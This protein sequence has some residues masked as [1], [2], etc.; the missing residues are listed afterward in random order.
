[1]QPISRRE[2]DTL[3]VPAL[4]SAHSHAFQRGLRGMAQ[5]KGNPSENFWTWRGAM[6][7]LAESLTPETID[8]FSRQAFR[9]LR[10]AGVRT[11]G[12][13]HYVHHQSGGHPYDDR[14]LL[15]DIVIR[16]ALDEGLRITLLRTAYNRG[17]FEHKIDRA[18]LRFS[19]K[20]VDD[21]LRDTETL[22]KRYAGDARVRIGLAPHSVRAVPPE[23]LRPLGEFAR[24]HDLPFHMHISEQ[25][26]EVDEC[27]AETGKRPL[28][29]VN[30]A[31]LLSERFC[32]V[33]ATQLS[34][35]EV[36]LLGQA[37]AFACLCPTTERDLGDGIADITAL[38]VA[39]VR[40]CNGIDS[41]I[42]T[43]PIEEIRSLET[44]ERLRTH[45]RV[46]FTNEGRTPA[47]S[48]WLEGS[49]NGSMACGFSD[50]GG[51]I[52]INA[53]HESLRFVSPSQL[54]DA[55]VFSGSA[56]TLVRNGQS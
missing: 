27:V 54:L 55:I 3:W 2:G 39:G 36:Q 17:G 20:D 4:A 43:D 6:F 42:V 52:A 12:E 11:V 51:E 21:V 18:Q 29:V 13:F 30:D 44:H 53:A 23:W 50:D 25:M 9:E 28:E 5:R 41:H 38:R 49:T 19:D 26:R 32:A 15:S 14:T 7:D 40:L 34:Q 1:M 48:L 47:E 33:H 8:A 31:G 37:H 46:T 24:R 56:N 45:T 35:H 22:L 16:A 10:L